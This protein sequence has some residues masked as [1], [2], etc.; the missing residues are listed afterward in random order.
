MSSFKLVKV[1]GILEDALCW[2]AT[3]RLDYK[4]VEVVEQTGWWMRA[5]RI[6]IFL[7][8]EIYN[9]LQIGDKLRLRTRSTPYEQLEEE[10]EEVYKEDF[11]ECPKCL[12]FTQNSNHT[13]AP[14]KYSLKI[15]GEG[16]ILA[17]HKNNG[18]Q[19][20]RLLIEY[21]EYPFIFDTLIPNLYDF[22]VGGTVKLSGWLRKNTGEFS[23]CLNKM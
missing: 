1:L 5:F 10:V 11:D 14:Q 17:V 19:K 8:D 20:F 4:Q 7:K 3:G 2:G 21:M 16:G 22:K 18:G 6:N 12:A 15:D 13:C 9:G 23:I